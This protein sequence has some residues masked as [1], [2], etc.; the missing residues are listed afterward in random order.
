MELYIIRHAQSQNNALADPS[1]RTCDPGL[2]GLGHRQAESLARHLANGR[3]HEPIRNGEFPPLPDDPAAPDHRG[4]TRLYCSAMWR[5]L[6]TAGPV[7]RA[8]GLTPQVWVDIHEEGGIWLDHGGELGILGYPGITRS[9]LLSAFPDYAVPDTI[10]EAGWWRGGHETW[11][12]CQ[13]RAARIAAELRHEAASD[14][15]IAVISHGG[16]ISALLAALLKTPVDDDIF[17]HHNNTGISLLRFR[18]NGEVRVR[19][20]NRV[21]HLAPELRT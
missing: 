13:T 20:L 4:I 17:Y 8:L 11:P 9:E 7:G 6:Y 1:T 12:E 21:E 19:Y 15:R 5:A 10:T 2:T 14:A 16:F 3:A 18:P